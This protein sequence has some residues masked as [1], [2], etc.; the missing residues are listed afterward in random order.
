VVDDTEVATNAR[1]LEA[2]YRE[3]GYHFARV[4]GSLGEHGE[5]RRIR[6]DVSEGPR[7]TVAAISVSGNQAIPPN[8]SRSGWRPSFQVFCA[9]A[10]SG[11]TS[12]IRTSWR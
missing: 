8:S 10:S 3:S 6:F 9:P 2:M 4:A 1:E 7:V 5:S 12:S 11:R